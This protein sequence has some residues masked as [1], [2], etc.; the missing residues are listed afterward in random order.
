MTRGLPLLL[1]IACTIYTAVHVVQSDSERVRVLPKF[2]W[3]II[4]LI[5]PIFG[6]VAWWIF[7]RPINTQ[8]VPPQAPDD[9]TDFL[10]R[11]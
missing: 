5:V 4:V 11:L 6:M 3:L 1:L 8:Y 2:L 10:R 9:D 7:G